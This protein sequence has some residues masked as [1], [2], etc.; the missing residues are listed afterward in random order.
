MKTVK[1]RQE[2]LKPNKKIVKRLVM[3]TVNQ[4]KKVIEYKTK[5][6][7]ETKKIMKKMFRPVTTIR[8]V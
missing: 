8:M 7:K 3:K 5:I 1:R 2:V 4:E 6:Y